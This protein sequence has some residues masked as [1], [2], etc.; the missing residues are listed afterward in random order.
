M[1]QNSVA[2]RIK[3]EVDFQQDPLLLT[4]DGPA[5]CCQKTLPTYQ[6]RVWGLHHSQLAA[7]WQQKQ[8]D[9][10]LGKAWQQADYSAFEEH[11]A[12]ATYYYQAAGVSIQKLLHLAGWNAAVLAGETTLTCKANGA[13]TVV[14]QDWQ[15]SN[16]YYYPQR[17]GSPVP[18][19]AMLAYWQQKNSQERE[20]GFVL[21][22]AA[23]YP[24]LLFGQR[25][26]SDPN[27][28][29]FVKQVQTLILGRESQRPAL[30]LGKPGGPQKCFSLAELFWLP[31]QWLEYQA[32]GAWH[33]C[34]GF[35]LAELLSPQ[36]RSTGVVLVSQTKTGERKR[37]PI[38]PEDGFLAVYAEDMR[39]GLPVP[40]ATDLCYYGAEEQIADVVALEIQA[41]AEL[42]DQTVKKAPVP[43]KHP[44]TS[45]LDLQDS[46]FYL[47]LCL[48]D[49]TLYYHFSL[50]E[51]QQNYEV[52]TRSCGF[53]DHTVDKIA[54][55]RGVLLEQLWQNLLDETGKPLRLPLDWQ[56]QVVEEDAY[57]AKM[58]TY[59]HTLSELQTLYQP[60]LTWQVKEVFVKPT[61]YNQNPKRAYQLAVPIIYQQ[62]DSANEAVLK[63]LQGIIISADGRG[64][65]PGGYTVIGK[66]KKSGEKLFQKKYR[67]NMRG[68]KIVVA[69]PQ[70][71][72]CRLAAG[73]PAS[74]FVT[75]GNAGET[76]VEFLLEQLPFFT[77]SDQ[78]RKKVY[79]IT[80]WQRQAKEVPASRE[81]VLEKLATGAAVLVTEENCYSQ[82]GALKIPP[83][84]ENLY[85]DDRKLNRGALPY[86]F[87]LFTMRRYQGHFLTEILPK[88]PWQRILL[89]GKDG[90]SLWLSQQDENWRHYFL[91]HAYT[92][93]KGMPNNTAEQKRK[94][95]ALTTLRLIDARNGQTV[96]DSVVS[97][98]LV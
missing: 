24:T 71:I 88:A 53:D 44:A 4:I 55:C 43:A 9:P 36:E 51:L 89:T 16:R 23:T 58:A 80:A 7:F 93:S 34:L 56:V 20:R 48:P 91:A 67:G 2:Q 31:L 52:M 21:Q 6:Q 14:L 12:A 32:A 72:G 10:F 82:T 46:V 73:E 42:S 97:A 75:A 62:A 64:F 49:K 85:L 81:K 22:E 8:Q 59:I 76:I 47:G 11:G 57:H 86:G 33:R 98:F 96:L 79:T 92:Q 15:K 25:E 74:Q 27:K 66:D 37:Q 63:G 29:S 95:V 38:Q 35:F 40:N 45:L 28:C 41:V 90:Q 5:G 60:M 17:Q 68:M 13:Y 61:F 70:V 3:D 84:K 65:Q 30:R 39:S 50:Q 26:Q 78:R 54:E 18:V 87:G 83:A 94:K 1:W 77:V 19:K 69:A